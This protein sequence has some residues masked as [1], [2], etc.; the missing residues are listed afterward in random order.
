MN[1]STKE[2]FRTIATIYAQDKRYA[3]EAYLFTLAALHFTVEALPEP[4]HVTG[5]ELVTGIRQYALDQFGAM[6]RAVFKHWGLESTEDFGR[7]VFTLVEHKILSK[8][9]QDSLNDFR[10]VFVFEE[11]FAPA[12][13][14]YTLAD[15]LPEIPAAR[16]P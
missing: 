15:D 13:I 6:A 16:Q 3:P 9:E 4:R 11:A 10:D 5:Q 1:E 7:M 14:S 12:A 8:T 2:L